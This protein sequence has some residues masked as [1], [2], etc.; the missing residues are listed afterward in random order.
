VI[1][2]NKGH[3]PAQTGLTDKPIGLCSATT[4]VL[5]DFF[6]QLLQLMLIFKKIMN[7][8]SYIFISE[9][10]NCTCTIGPQQNVTADINQLLINVYM[11]P[12]KL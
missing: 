12:D 10:V 5:I 11:N 6:S 1:F 2:L 9:R 7:F 8:S 3:R 4:E